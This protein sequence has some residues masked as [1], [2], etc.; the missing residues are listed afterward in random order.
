MDKARAVI[1]L[2]EGVIEL[3]GPVDFVQRYMD[4]YQP[5]TRRSRANK[6]AAEKPRIELRRRTQPAA[7]K[8]KEKKPG[9][10]TVAIRSFLDSGF[11][12]QPRTM[13]DVRRHLNQAGLV[14]TDRGIK[15]NLTRLTKV[16][17]LN[18]NGRGR[19]LRY[20][21]PLPA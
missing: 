20:H 21:R 6:R 18:A 8:A 4:A 14:F 9:S 19:A 16:H 17:S 3:E 1:N 2:K 12:D 15:V 7:G 11:F 5:P 13:G 10:S